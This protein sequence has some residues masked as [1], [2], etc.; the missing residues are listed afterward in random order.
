MKKF[1]IAMMAAALLVG[2]AYA[3][4]KPAPEKFEA[5]IVINASLT[6]IEPNGSAATANP[7]AGGDIYA[8]ALSPAA[9][10]DWFAFTTTGGSASFET[11]AGPAVAAG[12]TKIYL[13]GTNGTTQIGYD[14][15]GGAGFYSLVTYNFTAAG[16]YY[17]RVIHYSATG[18]GNYTLTS[19]AV[20]PPPPPAVNDLCAGAIDIQTQSLSAWDVNLTGA[21]GFSN[22][23]SLVYG[24]CTGYSTPGPDAIYKIDLVAG[25]QII[26]AESGACDMALW[27]A[28]D[29]ANLLTT[30]VA[31]ADAGVTGATEIVNFIPAV[32]GT[33]YVVVDAYTAGGCPVTVTVNAPVATEGASFGALKALFR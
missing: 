5:E 21:G 31:G 32:S 16:T 28:S 9:D 10:Q 15:D 12:D 7:I 22:N 27:I 14:D 2:V 19:T 24:G 20:A 26:I 6:E 8:A 11:G 4:S 25:E 30:C 1:A 33:Y 13:Y 29:C 17:V 18:T 23:Y 3:D